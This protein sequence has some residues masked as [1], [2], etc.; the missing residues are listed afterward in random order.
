MTGVATSQPDVA[1]LIEALLAG[2]REALGE[3]LVG[4]YLR[5]SLALGDFNPETSDVD[6]LVVTERRVSESEFKALNVFHER[7]PARENAFARAYEV[8][9][10]DRDSLRRFAPGERRHPTVGSDWHFQWAQHRDSFVLERWTVRERGVTV[11]GP[12]PKTLIDAISADELRAAATGELRA[13]MEHWAAGNEPPG[14]MDTR[15]YQA[16]EVETICRALYTIEFGDLPTKPQAV[17]WA[18]KTLPEPWHAL[19]EWS[20]AHR[21][22]KTADAG[23]IPDVMRFVRWAATRSSS[24]GQEAMFTPEVTALIE[25]HLTGVREALRDNLLGLYV[26]GSLAIGGFDPET[27]DVDVLVITHRPLS[28][29]EFEALREMHDRLRTLPN[30]YAPGLEAAYIDAAAARRFQPGQRHPT[31]TSHDPFRWERHDSNWVLERWIV[32]EHSPALFGPDPATVFDPISPEDLRTSAAKRMREWAHWSSAV[33]DEDRSW[34]NER[35]HQAYITETTCRALHTAATGLVPTKQAA[36]AWA[37]DSLPEE[38]RPLIQWSQQ[39]RM[40]GT[41]DETMIP[42]VSRFVEW[43]ARTQ[44]DKAKP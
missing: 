44:P 9:Y 39:H 43:A 1:R 5:G 12:A 40:D 16:F 33:P 37:Q 25:A 6:I 10:V 38:W 23:K 20:Q 18:Q 35:A 3:N 34:L 30:R 15:H 36:V 11:M 41:D 8:S 7:I 29:G 17:T 14:W 28:E 42:E 19:V 31:I 4:L 26:R 13:R 27:S 21:A 32:R 2:V 22:D 24:T